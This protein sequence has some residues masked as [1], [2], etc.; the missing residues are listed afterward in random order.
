MRFSGEQSGLGWR[1]GVT[2]RTIIGGLLVLLVVAAVACEDA[3]PNATGEPT[4]PSSAQ[5]A[6]PKPSVT[7]PP[8]PPVDPTEVEVVYASPRYPIPWDQGEYD[9][10]W[11]DLDADAAIIDQLLRAIERGTPV[12]V[13]DVDEKR[14]WTGYSSL[15]MNLRFRNGTTWSVRTAIRCDVTSEGRKT[16]C[17]PVPDHWELLHRNEVVVSTALTEWFERVQEY[18]PRVEYYEVPNPITLGE[19]FAISGAGYHEGDRVELSIKFLDESV[20][21][22]GDVPLDHGAFHW[23][24]EIP[25]SVH[26]GLVNI[27]MRSFEGTEVVAGITRE[28]VT[29]IGDVDVVYASQERQPRSLR[30]GEYDPL[31]GDLDGDVSAIEQLL[32]A[33]AIGTVGRVREEE[34]IAFS[35]RGLAVNVRFRD[36][37]IWSVRQVIKCNLTPEGRMTNCVS[38][39]DQY[40]WNL[41]HPSQIAFS[42]LMTDRAL[43]EWFE[44]VREYMPRVEFYE[45]PD[46]ITLGNPFTISGAG[47][48]EGDRVELS[49]KFSDQS[50]MP[51]GEVPL[52]HGAF[53]WEGVIPKTTPSGPASF[54]M[55]VL[56]GAE[57]VCGA[58]ISSVNVLAPT[59]AGVTTELPAAATWILDSLDGR[60]L[61]EE[62]FISLEVDRD[63]LWGW[64]G[65]NSFASQPG[66]DAAYRGQDLSV[67]GTI[68]SVTQPF[69]NSAL[70]LLKRVQ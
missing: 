25:E 16:K 12:E 70:V 36:G 17:L 61:I 19:P 33:I 29:V 18:M 32:K 11:G 7:T 31:W 53:R 63:G 9:P 4:G 45:V 23:E 35:D 51:L 2:T 42:R 21:P 5:V 26:P 24:G 41:L 44:Q 39:L 57:R 10:L 66:A 56:E 46:P 34:G 64:D 8:S 67:T 20:L 58:T 38:V 15:I 37:T 49:V 52:D 48:H 6:T 14:T 47:Y 3:E 43:T 54:T 30:P 22:L 65:C 68:H 60:P 27:T 55:Q 1:I 28:S 59:V 69:P 50:V 62:T 40:H 13:V